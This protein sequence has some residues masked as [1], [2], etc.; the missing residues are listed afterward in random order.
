[1]QAYLNLRGVSHV[2]LA[3]HITKA[4]DAMTRGM[5]LI[6]ALIWWSPPSHAGAKEILMLRVSPA[7]AF[8]PAN[9]VVRVTIE[10]DSHNRAM[11]IVAESEHF[12]RSSEI[13]L[14]GD[15]APRTTR[16][17]FRS[18]PSGVYEV[19]AVLNGA[20][21][22]PRARVRQQVNVMTSGSGH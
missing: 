14:N 11:L 7:V 13:E 4:V 21:G 5:I 17:E 20:A 8:A 3:L 10:A 1:M 12:Y 18:L 6:G 15:S 9:L 16:F 2:V 22:E 19:S